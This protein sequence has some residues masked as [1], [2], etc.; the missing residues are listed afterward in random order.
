MRI[1]GIE[2]AEKIEGVAVFH[3]GTTIENG[4]LVTSGGRVLSVSATGKTL[5]EALDRAYA[6]ADKIHFEGKYMRR[7]IGAKALN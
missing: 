6:A 3:A 2:E 4:Q 5:K 1:K 7:D